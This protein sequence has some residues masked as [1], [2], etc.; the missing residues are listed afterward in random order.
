MREQRAQH[1]IFFDPNR[2][3]RLRL[4]VAAWARLLAVWRGRYVTKAMESIRE[5]NRNRAAIRNYEVRNQPS[6]FGY[7]KP[8]PT[9][10]DNHREREADGKSLPRTDSKKRQRSWRGERKMPGR[11]WLL[12]LACGFSLAV[13]FFTTL[14]LIEPHLPTTAAVV[15]LMQAQITNTHSLLTAIKAAGLRG[16]P[17]VKGKID[18]VKRLNDSQVAIA[19]WAAEIGNSSTPLTVLAFVD[20][21]VA[22]AMRTSGRHPDV[23]SVLGASDAPEAAN[24]SFQGTA[25]CAHGQKL[26]VIAVTDGNSYG[27]FGARDCP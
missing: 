6:P 10:D 13:S 25:R 23:V 18:E 24:V 14:Y 7:Y 8:Y 16:S 11:R 22:L 3:T 20:G 17:N 21:K 2:C 9:F 12:L 26:I 1:G 27:H 15:A 5:R 4:G 19:G